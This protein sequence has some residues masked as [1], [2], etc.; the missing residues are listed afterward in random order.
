MFG[1]SFNASKND[2]FSPV[3]NL[4]KKNMLSK[5]HSNKISEKSSSSLGD[6][7]DLSP[8][9]CQNTFSHSFNKTNIS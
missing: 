2:G 8:Q 7:D 5:E 1:S 3:T 9:A 6:E 4:T